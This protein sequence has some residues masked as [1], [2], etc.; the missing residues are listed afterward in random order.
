MWPG[1]EATYLTQPFNPQYL[2]KMAPFSV[3]RFMDWGAT[4]GS[5]VVEWADRA[6]VS[7]LTYQQGVPIEVM[8]DLA[9]TLHVDPWFCIPHKASDD[10]VKQF[11]T[12]LHS[13]L[14]PGLHPHIEYS[15]EVWNMVFP[16][17]H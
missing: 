11:A 2:S 15:N 13:R 3:I 9:N 5:P 12:L 16:A 6:H 1:T 17:S 4:N 7:D 8:I 10:Y 14:D